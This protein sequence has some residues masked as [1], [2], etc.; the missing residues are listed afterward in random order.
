[1]NRREKM[2]A[3]MVVLIVAALGVK[4]LH[5]RYRDAVDRRA[6]AVAEA[7]DRLFAVNRKLAQG[8]A[9]VRQLQ[10]WESRSLPA[11]RDK[12]I[13]LYKAWLL[14]TAKKA[15]L[16]VN[17]I[18]PTSRPSAST[19]YTAIGYQIKA[20]GSLK[21]VA[22][23]LYEFYRSP[24]LH[25]ITRLQLTRPQ[26]A[27]NIE[28]SLDVEA[29]SLPRAEATDKLPEGDSKRLKLASVDDYQKTLDDR[30]LVNVYQP[31]RPPR[32]PIADRSERP[33]PEKFDDAEQA[34]FTAS[35]GPAEALQAWITVRTTGEAMHLSAGD[36][37]KVGLLEGKIV[38]I[39]GRSLI[40]ESEGK[41][42]R[43][44][45]G[46]SLRKGKE[47]APDGTTTDEKPLE[48][49]KS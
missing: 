41:K 11:D 34:H 25:Q 22:A 45:L 1:M 3:L 39:E 15:G 28:V 16:E 26:G 7:Q 24:Q 21:N 40:Y 48:T 31:P 17:D 30:D 14:E 33:K 23:M 18:N 42:Y 32:P 20:A 46:E 35:V 36:E 6:K 49:P 2:L 44:A 13:T 38:S 9:A 10:D 27:T 37:I 5:G 29:L 4:S 19:A 47:L 43:V 8:R 12:A